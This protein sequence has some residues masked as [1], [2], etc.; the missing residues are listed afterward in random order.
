MK[1]W[2][3]KYVVLPFDIET[4]D[5]SKGAMALTIAYNKLG[6]GY[7]KAWDEISKLASEGWE[8]IS[9]VAYTRSFTSMNGSM[10]AGAGS[11]ITDGILVVLK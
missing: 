1:K 9:T 4:D 8:P 7:K 5:R 3:V 10:H 6:E 11:S 2:E